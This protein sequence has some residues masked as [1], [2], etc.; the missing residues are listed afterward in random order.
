MWSLAVLALSALA[1]QEPAVPAGPRLEPVSDAE[2]ALWL[3]QV[4]GGT[5]RE[6]MLTDRALE[7]AVR[8]LPV[9][10]IPA[11]LRPALEA[12]EAIALAQLEARIEGEHAGD[13]AAWL[14]QLDGQG[15]PPEEALRAAT[16][17]ALRETRTAILVRRQRRVG[18]A[19][20]ARAFE[21]RFGPGGVRTEAR[22]LLVSYAGVRERVEAA[23]RGPPLTEE[24]VRRLARDEAARLRQD[25]VA[26]GGLEALGAQP[27]PEGLVRFAGAEF[28][29]AL[30]ALPIGGISEPIA[31]RF[32]V[33]VLEVDARTTA[34]LEDV[35]T[36]LRTELQRAAPSL[37]ERR[38]VLDA[39][40]AAYGIRAAA[41]RRTPR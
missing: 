31:T 20:V 35:E 41:R 14:R 23:R 38:A 7:R 24:A 15:L 26:A 40:D 8:A 34:R 27:V 18:E 11:D 36:E 13:R 9:D 12:P 30:D 22:Q 29:A 10:E 2:Y 19:D 28:Q 1:P 39:L 4:T 3:A 33:H 16:V 17:F 32:G 6:E 21:E 5:R 25:A 37:A